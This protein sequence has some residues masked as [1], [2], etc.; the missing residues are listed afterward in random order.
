MVTGQWGDAKVLGRGGVLL[1]P[2]RA[3]V[4]TSDSRFAL[5]WILEGQTDNAVAL[6]YCAPLAAS[7]EATAGQWRVVMQDQL[8]Q[9]LQSEIRAGVIVNCT[10]PW[11]DQVNRQFGF[12]TPF[13]HV[14]SK[15][16]FIGL[17]R[18]PNHE[19]P[20][21]MDV[22]NAG[23]CMSLIPWGPISLWGPTESSDPELTD[24]LSTKPAD[25]SYLLGEL[26]KFLTEPMVV[27][28][29]ISVRNGARSLVVNTNARAN[30]S[31]LRL[32]RKFEVCGDPERPWISVYGGK[33]T[34]CERLAQITTAKIRR[35]IGARSQP[36]RR[37]AV[38]PAGPEEFEQTV[39]PGL[40]VPVP[41]LRW[42]VNRELCC[43]LDDYLRRR[44]NIAQWV[45]RGGLGRHN[46]YRNYLT[47]IA[48]E[49]PSVRQ[50]AAAEAVR[51]Y[52]SRVID[53]VD[54][55]IAAC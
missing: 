15:G 45:P 14:F 7:F 5:R 47:E 21:I 29:I 2:R 41:T 1:F 39:Y 34:G 30:Q 31:T 23:D 18:F 38:A 19:L 27:A 32:S 42:C 35:L 40:A 8:D 16:V 20:L 52:E 24:A 44:T 50:S 43:T 11:T 49:L 25:I 55:L 4:D 51:W 22:G 48:R 13:K 3:V 12:Q 37:Q 46:E 6:N 17:P 28:D 54:N 10:G 33:L 9:D 26:N 53:R 36:H